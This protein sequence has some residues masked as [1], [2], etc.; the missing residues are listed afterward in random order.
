MCGQQTSLLTLQEKQWLYVIRNEV[1]MCCRTS[2]SLYRLDM[3]PLSPF[4][5]PYRSH[6]SL[7]R[8][9]INHLL[10]F[11]NHMGPIGILL[12]VWPLFYSQC[13]LPVYTWHSLVF[14]YRAH[15]M[16]YGT[17]TGP[18]IHAYYIR[19]PVSR[20]QSRL[21]ELWPC[22][23]WICWS[24]PDRLCENDLTC[25]LLLCGRAFLCC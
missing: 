25:G 6:I 8:W 2:F 14:L 1:H 16:F 24:R 18:L 20:L 13:W 4:N 21:K 15:I 10:H 17:E 23:D 19:N 5:A 11:I 3:V 7:F 12:Q 22:V 9:A